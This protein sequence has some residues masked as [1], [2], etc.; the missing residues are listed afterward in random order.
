MLYHDFFFPGLSSSLC[1][2]ITELSRSSDAV[3]FPFPFAFD[4]P[5]PIAVDI[6]LQGIES[7][8]PFHLSFLDLCVSLALVLLWAGD[9]GPACTGDSSKAALSATDGAPPVVGESTFSWVS[10]AALSVDS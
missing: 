9:K 3:S 2:E 6:V 8:K 10:N 1:S 5:L 4:L 7:L